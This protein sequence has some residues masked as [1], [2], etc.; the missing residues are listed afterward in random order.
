MFCFEIYSDRDKKD[1]L[2]Q[3]L[4]VDKRKIAY[5]ARPF[6]DKIQCL[7]EV[8]KIRRY[9]DQS[10][11]VPDEEEKIRGEIYFAYFKMD[12]GSWAWQIREKDTKKTLAVGEENFDGE[13]EVVSYIEKLKKIT[14]DAKIYWQD[15]SDR[16]PKD[17]TPGKGIPGSWNEG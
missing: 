7:G 10:D 6:A 13:R 8:K 2:W 1:W 17:G 16:P 12:S 3:L 4:D 11:I 9:I 15:P 14:L 5:S